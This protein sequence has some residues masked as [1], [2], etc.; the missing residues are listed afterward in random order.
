MERGQG[1]A[2]DPSRRGRGGEEKPPLTLRRPRTT[3]I[4]GAVILVVLAIIGLG[5]SDR[6]KPTSLDIAG[7]DS[8]AANELLREHFGDS[9]PF[10]ILL[11]GPAEELDRQGPRLI[12]ALREDPAVTT[13]SPWDRGRV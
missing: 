12:R 11:Q 6:L 2:E 13:L 5:V 8:S 9:A 7:T 10:V 3:L 1:A 4:L